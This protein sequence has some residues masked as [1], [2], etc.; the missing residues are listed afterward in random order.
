VQETWRRNSGPSDR[1]HEHGLKEDQGQEPAQSAVFGSALGKKCEQ[2]EVKR[3][4]QRNRFKRGAAGARRNHSALLEEL[5]GAVTQQ[6]Y[7]GG[8]KDPRGMKTP[9]QCAGGDENSIVEEVN[10]GWRKRG[11]ARLEQ[12]CGGHNNGSAGEENRRY[13]SSGQELHGS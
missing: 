3:N 5:H 6:Q 1:G 12:E 7:Y 9:R 10:P 4:Q 13:R 2:D 8:K 11:P